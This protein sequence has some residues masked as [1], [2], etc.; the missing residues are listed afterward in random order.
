MAEWSTKTSDDFEDFI[1]VVSST[2]LHQKAEIT[3]QCR[4][5]D[6]CAFLDFT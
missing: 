1:D 4:G 5:P 3:K 6:K 2:T